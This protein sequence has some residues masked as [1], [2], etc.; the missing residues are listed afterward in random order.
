M[1]DV[2]S[3]REIDALLQALSS[4]EVSAEA[5]KE[6]EEQRRIRAYDFKRAMRFSKD[7]LRSLTRIYENYARMLSTYFS[8]QLRTW[9]HL[10]VI[11]VEQLPYEEFI[12]S[13]PQLSTLLV[14]DLAPLSGRWVIGIGPDVAFVMLDRL[15]GGPGLELAGAR[16]FT[17]IETTVFERSWSRSLGV[18]GDAWKG[19]VEDLRPTLS[20]IEFNPQFLQIAA[21]NDTVAVV[22]VSMRIMET[23]GLMHIGMPHLTLERL[24][25]K[26]SSQHMLGMGQAGRAL[27]PAREEALRERLRAAPVEIRAVLGRTS[28]DFYDLMHL[29]AGD[30]IPLHQSVNRPVEIYVGD[31]V[32]YLG[33]PGVDHGRLAVQITEIADDERG[34]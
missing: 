9:M 28:I 23:T 4:G 19:I 24:L 20:F 22:S 16:A 29:A 1:A 31:R 18:L 25:P 5:M 17:E 12:R 6:E 15:L 10:D 11:S 14:V 21:P 7:Q 2:L 34:E 13:M 30:V 8:A 26:L 27:D 33:R 3:Q 32:K